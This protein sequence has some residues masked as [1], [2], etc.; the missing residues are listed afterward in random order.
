MVLNQLA[1]GVE[2]RAK[3]MNDNFML[4]GR[5][6]CCHVLTDAI[7]KQKIKLAN[8]LGRIYPSFE[9]AISIIDLLSLNNTSLKMQG[10]VNHEVFLFFYFTYFFHPIL[11]HVINT[12]Y[13][14]IVEKIRS[15]PVTYILPLSLL[16]L[17]ENVS[18]PTIHI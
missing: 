7:L 5:V 9:K 18:A 2:L 13:F 15:V 10:S 4:F 12:G 1:D 3:T 11:C 14:K 16:N 6:S 8:T 17:Y